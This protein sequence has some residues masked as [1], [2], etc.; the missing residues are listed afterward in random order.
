MRRHQW[1]SRGRQQRY[2]EIVSPAGV[3]GSPMYVVAKTA[4]VAIS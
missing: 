4:I 3:L 2:S 1:S